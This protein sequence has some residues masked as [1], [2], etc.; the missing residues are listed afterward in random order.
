MEFHCTKVDGILL[1]ADEESAE[2]LADLGL[3]TLVKCSCNK[4]RNYENHKR[5]FA[6]VKTAFDMQTHFESF[7]IFRKWLIMGA[8]YYDTAVTPKGVTIFLPKSIAFEKLDEEE[9][10]QLFKK[11]IDYYLSQLT[12]ARTVSNEEFMRILDFE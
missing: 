11:A 4:N 3:D 6:F 2:K 5:F 8:G 12:S 7:D 10:K 1:G 9:F